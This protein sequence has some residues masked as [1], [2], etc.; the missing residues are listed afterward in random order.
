MDDI[1]LFRLLLKNFGLVGFLLFFDVLFLFF[2]ILF[3]F[4]IKG[5]GVYVNENFEL[6]FFLLYLLIELYI[7]VIFFVL[8]VVVV[9]VL[10]RELFIFFYVCYVFDIF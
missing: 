9:C 4:L 2:L 5:F 7:D 1:G 8:V 10:D 3:L 6:V